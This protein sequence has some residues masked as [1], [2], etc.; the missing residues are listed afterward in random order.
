MAVI[1]PSLLRIAPFDAQVGTSVYFTFTGSKQFL[2]NELEIK[3]ASDSSIV[4]LFEFSSFEKV[5]HIPPNVL[6]NGTAYK[7]RIRVKFTD[8]SYS[9]YSNEVSFNAF[10]SPVVDIDNIDGQGY[11]YNRDVTFVANYSQSDGEKVRT[12]QFKLY[13]E[14]QDLIEV[15]PVRYPKTEEFTEV[16]NDLVKGKGYFIE[17]LISTVNGMVYSHREKFIP[18]YIVPSV[19]GLITTR[20]DEEEGFVRITSNLKQITGTQ[21]KGEKG[22]NY[23]SDNYEYIDGDMVV[24]PE[25]NPVIFRGLDMNRASDFVMKIWCRDIPYGTNF[26]RLIPKDNE[27]I[28]IDFWRYE[29]RVVAVKNNYGIKAR[30]R[31]NIYNIPQGTDFMLYAKAIEHRLDLSIKIV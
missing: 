21:V 1:K 14:N 3:K 18:M 16:V 17:C 5:H 9:P 19:N 12:Y 10:D 4:Y 29:D 2:L 8:G 27:G 25:N 6:V 28:N 24:V 20:N 22:D 26:L 7:A 13:D 31:S 11:V 30:Y 23:S 15:Y